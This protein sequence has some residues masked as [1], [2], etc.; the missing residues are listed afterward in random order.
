MMRA[1]TLCL[2]LSC[3]GLHAANAENRSQAQFEQE[4]TEAIK[5]LAT[6]LK[7]ALMNAMQDGGP[8]EA[9]NV[10]HTLA[11]V[12]AANVSEKYGLTIY[13]TSRKIRNTSNSPDDWENRVMEQF[14]SRLADG[15]AI[16]KLTFSEKVSTANSTEWRM[17]KAIP[18]D[19]VCL[20]CHGSKIAEPIQA[21]IM[22]YYPDDMATGFKLGEI[23]GAFSVRKS[24]VAD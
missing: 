3:L 6:H 5:E 1:V 15:E 22:Q 18:T 13:R 4:A 7:G 11:P 16:Q 23:R 9:V 10:C 2:V 8:V 24:S 21:A 17:M 12:L 19:K 14:E 20:S